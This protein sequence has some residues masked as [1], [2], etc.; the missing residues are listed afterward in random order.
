MSDAMNKDKVQ[1]KIYLFLV[2]GVCFFLGAA[3]YFTQA[4]NESIAYQILHKGFTA[5]P[6]MSAII[7]RRI[8]NN[9]NIG[10]LLIYR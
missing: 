9:K 4:S 5:F 3:A 8:T 1:I 2:L 6:V 7:A 10:E